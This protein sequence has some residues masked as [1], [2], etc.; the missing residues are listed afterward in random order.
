MGWIETWLR[1]AFA[2]AVVAAAFG[3][4]GGAGLAVVARHVMAPAVVLPMSDHDFAALAA[5]AL[6]PDRQVDADRF[7]TAL[8]L[9]R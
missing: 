7:E 9:N 2:A 8:G 4:G 3:A 6:T 1:R 5:A